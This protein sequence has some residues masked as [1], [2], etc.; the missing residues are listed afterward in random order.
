MSSLPSTPAPPLST[1]PRSAN[2]VIGN[3]SFVGVLL[4][5]TAGELYKIRRRAMSK[6]LLLIGAVIIA[7]AFSIIPLTV[8]LAESG[9]TRPSADELSRFTTPL[10]LPA[11]LI[12]T[13]RIVEN[14]GV[15]LFV[16]LAGTIVGGEY[17]VG[18]IRVLLTRGPTRTQY[19]LAKILAILIYIAR[20]TII[21]I[22]TG[23]IVGTLYG[24]WIGIDVNYSFFTS[25]WVLHAIIYI[26]LVLLKLFIYAIIALSLATLGKS[27]AAGVAGGIV[28][29]FLEG[30]LGPILLGVGLIN[31]GITGDILKTIPEYFVGNNIDVLLTEQGDYLVAAGKNA[32][33][34]ITGNIP[35]WRAWLVIAAYLV[36][37]L[38]ITW[39][40]L[41]RRDI[42]N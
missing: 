30:L 19:L 41:Q 33:I 13:G 35:D 22:A 36:V 11:S 20:T 32:S 39:W 40:A 31:P 29:W 25:D 1:P 9:Q 3:Q 37:F 21:L 5:S 23:I 24:L 14:V 4:R 26:L 2:L 6:I 18:T 17:G 12:M 34:T 7:I 16:I 27:T 10:H 15:V 38:G 8:F 42:T 28:W